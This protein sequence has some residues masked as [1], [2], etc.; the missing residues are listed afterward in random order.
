MKKKFWKDKRVLITGHTGFKGSWLSLWLQSKGAHVI[1]YSLP[2]PTD[3][4]L[5]EVAQVAEGMTSITGDIRNIENLISIVGE[6]NP[7]III[8]MAAQ[9]L[10]RHSY[11][12]PL[13]TYSTNVM[14]TANVLEAGR[15]RND[16]KVILIITSDKCYENKEWVWGYRES[17]PMGGHDP[18]SSSKGCAELITSAYL[19][20]FYAKKDNSSYGTA[21]A[22]ARAGN[23]IGGGDWAADRLVPDIMKAIMKNRPVIIRYPNAIRPWQHVL[24]PLR[25]YITLVER[26]WQHGEAFSGAWNFGPNDEDSRPV[27]WVAEH[28]AKLWGDGASWE[29]DSINHPHEATYLK[30]D[31]SKAKTKL[32][33]RPILDLN[34]TLQWMVEWYRA[35]FQNKDILEISKIEILRYEKILQQQSLKDNDDF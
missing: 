1:G 16:L 10:V 23:V 25:G 17:D 32:G 15:H 20:S 21:L 12:D 31:C 9:S 35:Y 14:G 24:E 18:Y 29:R 28:L 5:F 27:S 19:R 34:T 13:D 7:E 8:H 6:Y 3:P 33:W 4:S 11:K 2:P 30:L 22:T 26:L